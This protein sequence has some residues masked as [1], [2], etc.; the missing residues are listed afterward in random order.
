M[1]VLEVAKQGDINT[2]TVIKSHENHYTIIDE[3][4]DILRYWYCIKPELL[5]TLE[6][7]TAALPRTGVNAGN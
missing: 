1:K 4:H 5:R 6:E 7:T 2:F 3:E